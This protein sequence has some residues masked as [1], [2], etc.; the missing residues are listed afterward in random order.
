MPLLLDNSPALVTG[1]L[2]WVVGY[3]KQWGWALYLGEGF[4]YLHDGSAI[5]KYLAYFKAKTVVLDRDNFKRFFW[6]NKHL[7]T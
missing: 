3:N 6:Y 2:V 1:E 7:F 4:E 5:K